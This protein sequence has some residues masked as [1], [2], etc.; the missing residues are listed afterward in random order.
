VRHDALELVDAVLHVGY[1]GF[2]VFG[3]VV[4]VPGRHI[5]ELAHVQ[6]T[7]KAHAQGT[8]KAHMKAGR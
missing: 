2:A 5:E 1:P 4:G 7:C 3:G 8:C 6:G